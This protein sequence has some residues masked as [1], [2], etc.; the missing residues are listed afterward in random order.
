MLVWQ[1]GGSVY[2]RRYHEE[3]DY[4]LMVATL[5]TGPAVLMLR[6]W[7]ASLQLRSDYLTLAGHA[8]SWFNTLNPAIT[9][10]FNNGEFT[11]ET[12]LTKR[13]YHRNED[14]GREGFL[15]WTTG[16]GRGPKSPGK[17]GTLKLVP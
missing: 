9:W 3:N 15:E 16:M 12:E 7:R 10:Q 8:L 17:F 6:K 1:S 2:W 11:L 5:N 13:K 14:D 4:D